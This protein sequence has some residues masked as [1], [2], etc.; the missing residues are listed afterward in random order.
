M[1]SSAL[2]ARFETDG[3]TDADGDVAERDDAEKGEKASP[4]ST[5]P[6]IITPCEM[7]RKLVPR[8]ERFWKRKALFLRKAPILATNC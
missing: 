3:E 4:C 5:L 6:S 7:D 1:G 8:D 2:E